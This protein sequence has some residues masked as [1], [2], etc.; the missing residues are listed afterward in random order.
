MP[1]EPIDAK[2]ENSKLAAVKGEC[3]AGGGFGFWGVC[4]TANGAHGD[5]KISRGVVGTSEKFQGVYAKSQQNVGVA[6][7][8][9]QM[10][11][12]LG[13][14]HGATG[15]GVLGTND[16]GGDGV[17]GNG[18]RGVVGLSDAFQGVYGHS[19][20]NAGVVGESDTFDGVWGV[21]SVKDKSGVF[22]SNK[23]GGT[24]VTGESST[25]RGV[26]GHSGSNTGVVGESDTFDGVWGIAHDKSKAGI[27]GKN[28]NG[29]LA[30]YFDGDVVILGDLS[31]P[32]ADCAEEFDVAGP[33]A[34]EPGSVM[35]LGLAG[36]LVA[37]EGPYDKRVA[38]VVSGAGTYKPGIVMDKQAS[39]SNRQ[40]IAL[41][42]KVF[43]KVDADFAAVEIGDLLT[44]SPT[45]GHAM[46]ASDPQ[47][48][49]GSVIGKALRPLAAGRDL[50]PI[51]IALQ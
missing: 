13:V 34:A 23:A 20:A 12:V 3:T 19:K 24:G 50:V 16:N 33:E 14:C 44:T 17:V 18:R 15:A 22:G 46:K 40:P 37:S 6:G 51:L 30:G 49:F 4:A 28:L 1:A 7:E 9:D 26:Y 25:F 48:A 8:S 41:I 32:N 42:G 31:L 35:V 5:S 39:A 43:C 36:G 45:R 29:G 21:A 10:N 27:V 38:G 2:S 47:R 11:G